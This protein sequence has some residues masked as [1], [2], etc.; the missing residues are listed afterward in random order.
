MDQY[1]DSRFAFPQHREIV[2]TV[3]SMLVSSINTFVCHKV[4]LEIFFVTPMVAD[5]ALDRPVVPLEKAPE[6]TETV[7]PKDSVCEPDSPGVEVDQ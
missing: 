3:N 6:V 2:S 4:C 5:L 1:S 7:L